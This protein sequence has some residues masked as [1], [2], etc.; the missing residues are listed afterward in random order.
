VPSCLRYWGHRNEKEAHF[1][2]EHSMVV[3]VKKGKMK[4]SYGRSIYA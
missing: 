2:G 4:K 3:G 1:K